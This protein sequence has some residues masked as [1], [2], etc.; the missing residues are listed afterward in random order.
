MNTMKAALL[1][2]GL[3]AC[4]APAAAQQMQWTDQGFVNVNVGVQAGSH[5][6]A[7]NTTF[8]LYDE[9]ATISSAQ[10]VKSGAFFD[11]GAGYK[12]WRNV[13]V[14]L[15][16]LHTSSDAS[17]AIAGSIPDPLVT[18]RPRTVAAA[19]SGVKHS[20]DALNFDATYMMPVTDKIDVGI[21]A[22]P[23]I[24]FVK[25]DM[26]TSLPITEPGP[27]VGTPVLS[28]VKK[29]TAGVNFGVDVNYMVTKRYGV[30]GVARY[31]WGSAKLAGATDS[32]TVGGFQIGGG[33]RVRF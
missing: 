22:G 2:L 33:L 27:A 12:V 14:G 1:V 29:T 30:G 6:L 16:Y 18:D 10:K 31:T 24:F 4:A 7:T 11:V 32:L 21:S 5:D 25:Q 26:V 8:T 15:T 13:T 17:V 19:A 28:K 20:E 9:N 23:T 3:C